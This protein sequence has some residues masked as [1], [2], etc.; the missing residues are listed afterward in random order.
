MY[1]V[2]VVASVDF[3]CAYGIALLLVAVA[4]VLLFCALLLQFI[5]LTKKDF[6][7]RFRAAKF[8]F[9]QTIY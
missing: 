3:D 9:I 8:G 7:L 4:A 2:S 5:A 1:A 6:F